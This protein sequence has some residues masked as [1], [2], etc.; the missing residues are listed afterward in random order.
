MCRLLC[1]QP[2]QVL[3]DEKEK[4]N[5]TSAVKRERES[6]CALLHVIVLSTSFKLVSIP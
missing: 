3:A 2:A 4:N 5:S 1:D 6:V